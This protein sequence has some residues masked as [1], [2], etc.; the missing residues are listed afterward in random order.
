MT[1]PVR[2]LPQEAIT[3]LRAHAHLGNTVAVRLLADRDVMPERRP[4]A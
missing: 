1:A 3:V 2:A 4:I